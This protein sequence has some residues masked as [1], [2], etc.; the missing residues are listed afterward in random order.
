MVVVASEAEVVGA[1]AV[2]ARGSMPVT[3]GACVVSDPP[4]GSCSAPTGSKSLGGPG[5]DC[6]FEGMRVCFVCAIVQAR[7]RVSK[8]EA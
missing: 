1:P 8:R 5:R 2:A 7:A 6:C 3:A 4:A